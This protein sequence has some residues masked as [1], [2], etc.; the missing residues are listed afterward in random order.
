M[1]YAHH[2][3][4]HK[5]GAQ[6]KARPVRKLPPIPESTARF[7][8]LV[9]PSADEH[10]VEKS[11]PLLHPCPDVPVLVFDLDN[12]LLHSCAA[13]VDDGALAAIDVTVDKFQYCVHLRP[14]ADR[15]LRYLCQHAGFFRFGFWSAGTEEYVHAVLAAVFAHLDVPDWKD[16]ARFVRTRR[17]AWLHPAS[18]QYVKSLGAIARAFQTTKVLLIDDNV[19]H[20]LVPFNFGRIVLVP[21][22]QAHAPGAS[23]DTVLDQLY[24][25]ISK[26][27]AEHA[28][29]S[30]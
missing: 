16:K 27:H 5:P 23:S 8:D 3:I 1:L 28:T 10:V 18:G 30:E 6:H 24:A 22:F 14:G 26:W 4:V 12:T 17:H 25:Q 19:V 15:V 2:R 9:V 20:T 11:S 7:A 13:R 29:G 21:P